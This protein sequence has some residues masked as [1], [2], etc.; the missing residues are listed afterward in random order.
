[1]LLAKC[2]ALIWSV[3][4]MSAGWPGPTEQVSQD[5]TPPLTLAFYYPWYGSPDGPSGAWVHWRGV[6][7]GADG[8][9][10]AIAN[11]G[12]VPTLGAYDSLDPEVIDK[13]MRWAVAAGLDGLVVSWWGPGTHEDR[14]V[15]LLL[16]AAAE[17]GLVVSLYVERTPRDRTGIDAAEATADE[18]LGLARDYGGHPAFLRV[19][20]RPVLFTYVRMNQ[21]LTEAGWE[22]VFERLSAAGD[23]AP[24]IIGDRPPAGVRASFAGWHTYD[25]MGQIYHERE[26]HA[27]LSAWAEHTFARWI[28]RGRETGGITCVT[29]CPG[30]DDRYFRTPGVVVA[31]EGGET[32]RVLWEE[33]IEAGPDW[34]L[35]TSFNEWHETSEIEPSVEHGELY[36]E[37]T[38]EM[39]DR[40]HRKGSL[41]TKERPQP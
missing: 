5:T 13:H 12:N 11:S 29:I 24:L 7:T 6:E 26:R 32:Y 28:A 19:G 20:D 25:P 41:G 40:R 18:L 17:H 10:T 27:G 39:I 16:D 15:P 34:V 1:M 22:A 37:I 38:R 3:L 36:L 23:A 14:A 2:L 9:I 33:A 8:E 21:Q 4:A 35:I 31:R 30:Y